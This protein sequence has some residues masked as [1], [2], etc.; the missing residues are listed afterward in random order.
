MDDRETRLDSTELDS[1]PDP[2]YD[3]DEAVLYE[4]GPLTPR[5]VRIASLS[6][7]GAPIEDICREVGFNP[8]SVR[9][10][11]IT[12]KI[13]KE[14]ARIVSRP[15]AE[16]PTARTRNLRHEAIDAIQTIV[17][18][19]KHRQNFEAARFVVEQV[20][21][22]ATQKIEVG[23]N[24][25]IDFIE[26]V[27]KFRAAGRTLKDVTP[28]QPPQNILIEGTESAKEISA[29]VMEDILLEFHD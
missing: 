12:P 23:T 28:Q 9:R 10:L 21:G 17:R 15:L 29:S 22:K 3:I 8:E 4:D 27:D 26:R 25:L 16:D 24:Q 13:R 14:I 18:D 1:L 7:A 5:Y 20:E 19:P 6:A 2:P 11:L